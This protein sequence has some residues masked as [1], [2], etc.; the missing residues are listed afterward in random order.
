MKKYSLFSV[1][2]VIF[3]SEGF[4]QLWKLRRVE[5]T[6]GFGTTHFMGDV[7][8]FTEGTNYNG[9]RDISFQNTGWNGCLSVGYRVTSNF[10]ARA[11]FTGGYLSADDI[12]GSNADRG[13]S[14]TISF[15]EAS[16]TGQVFF[17]KNKM[18]NRYLFIR[19]K[20]TPLFPELH[21]YDVY[22]F[23][24]L[25]ALSYQVKPNDRLEAAPQRTALSG[26]IP[27]FPAGIGVARNFPRNSKLGLELGRRFTQ[28]DEI[29][30][31]SAA[32]SRRDVYYFFDITYTW[33]IRTKRFPSF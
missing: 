12:R 4:S 29:D 5:L 33:K 20:S 2:L 19:G 17:I 28:S 22:A 31:Y 23:A 7:G 8:G 27:V 21:Y 14:A 6:G 25:G 15:F 30:G 24:G 26:I 3:Y 11:D 9:L 13:F 18:E 1:F 16:L 32:G 10:S